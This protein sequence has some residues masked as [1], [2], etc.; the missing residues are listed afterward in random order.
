MS[1]RTHFQPDITIVEVHGAV[2]ACNA[3]RLSDCVDDLASRDR[4]L[5][6]DLWGVD[7]FGGEGFRALVRIAEKFERTKV[8]WA[9]AT[10]EAVD[11]LLCIADTHYRLPVAASVGEAPQQLTLDHRASCL[12]HRV[13]PA[14]SYKMI[15]PADR[16]AKTMPAQRRLDEPAPSAMGPPPVVAQPHTSLAGHAPGVESGMAIGRGD[17]GVIA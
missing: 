1:L 10:S 11:R 2:D 12:P 9:L 15:R 4:P 3:E 8:R 5:I 6:L 7:F 16:S 13:T 17:A 14:E